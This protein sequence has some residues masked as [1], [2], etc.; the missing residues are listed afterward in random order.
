ILSDFSESR[1]VLARLAP[2]KVPALEVPQLSVLLFICYATGTM[3]G[4]PLPLSHI[5]KA[6]W[7]FPSW[8]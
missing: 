5:K 8:L 4:H 1:R 7:V 3:A 6:S 2:A